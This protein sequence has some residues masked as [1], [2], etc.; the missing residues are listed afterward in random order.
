[1][2]PPPEVTLTPEASAVERE[3]AAVQADESPDGAACSQLRPPHMHLLLEL[4]DVPQNVAVLTRATA[5]LSEV[6]RLFCLGAAEQKG[7][8]VCAVP[9]GKSMAAKAAAPAWMQS[10]TSFNPMMSYQV[11]LMTGAEDLDDA[12]SAPPACEP[13]GACCGHGRG[14]C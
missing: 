5:M 6:P 11:D 2:P 10:F 3:P 7:T 4:T 13:T 1:M 14:A 8:R 12:T 9:Q